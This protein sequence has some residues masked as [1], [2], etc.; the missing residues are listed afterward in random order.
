MANTA[1][2]VVPAALF[3]LVPI[4]CA[5]IPTVSRETATTEIIFFFNME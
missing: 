4:A 3:A 5:G 1:V 2:A